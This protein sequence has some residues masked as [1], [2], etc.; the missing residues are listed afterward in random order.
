[1]SAA[2]AVTAHYSI[3]GTTSSILWRNISTGAD[4]V[5]YMNGATMTSW[6]SITPAVTDQTWEIAGVLH[7]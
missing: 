5:W 6:V 2:E 4:V 7:N 1:M 3:T